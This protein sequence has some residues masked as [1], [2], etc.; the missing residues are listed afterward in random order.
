MATPMIRIIPSNYFLLMKCVFI[1]IL[2]TLVVS[3][4][5]SERNIYNSEQKESGTIIKDSI[6]YGMGYISTADLKVYRLSFEEELIGVWKGIDVLT[7]SMDS[8][9]KV[10][11]KKNEYGYHT[12]EI[13]YDQFFADL[14]DGILEK[15]G[16]NH[17]ITDWSWTGEKLDS[18]ASYVIQD[19]GHLF[20]HFNQDTLF[21]GRP[22]NKNY[23]FQFWDTYSDTSLTYS[24]I[25]ANG[26]RITDYKLFEEGDQTYSF[27]DTISIFDRYEL[28]DFNIKFNGKYFY[29]DDDGSNDFE[30]IEIRSPL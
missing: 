13:L 23:V 6:Y 8:S 16:N 24:Y 14:H 17:F 4:E 27:W 3:C 1:L 21:Y 10:I 7:E 9:V 30:I 11:Y 22:L 20:V 5:N 29:T 12:W 28:D 19:N 25:K 18:I 26:K 2:S 15:K